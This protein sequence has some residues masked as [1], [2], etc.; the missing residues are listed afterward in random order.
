MKWKRT[1]SSQILPEN[2]KKLWN[3][4]VIV[5]PLVIGTLGIVTKGLVQRLEEFDIRGVKTIQTGVLLR[6]AK[7][8]RRVLETQIP[9]ENYQLT[10]V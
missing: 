9:V 1:I 3:I 7:I 8:R 2:G 4:K 6:S 5:I 10:P